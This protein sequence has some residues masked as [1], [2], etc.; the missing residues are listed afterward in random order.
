MDLNSTIPLA[1]AAAFLAEIIMYFEFQ[2]CY[3]PNIVIVAPRA[4]SVCSFVSLVQTNLDTKS[5]CSLVTKRSNGF[6]YTNLDH[7]RSH[8]IEKNK[9][10]T[11]LVHFRVSF[12]FP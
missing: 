3:C 1:I 9:K 12:S 7:S 10:K 4:K 11:D 6:G 2:Q 8:K 5:V